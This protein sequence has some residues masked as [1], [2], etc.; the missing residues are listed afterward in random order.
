MRKD[1]S[2]GTSRDFRRTLKGKEGERQT[3]R[4]TDRSSNFVEKEA[5]AV[6]VALL[7]KNFHIEK[8]EDG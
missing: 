6:V 7:K 8:M 1:I 2:S 5:A 3:I 4:L